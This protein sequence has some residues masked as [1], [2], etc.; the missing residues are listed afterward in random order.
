MSKNNE[1]RF[2]YVRNAAE[3]RQAVRLRK[4]GLFAAVC[5]VS[6]CVSAA[7]ANP[8]KP[9]NLRCERLSEPVAIDRDQPRLSWKL[10]S[11][12]RGEKQTAYR[13]LVASSADKLDKDVGDLWDTGKVESNQSIH[14]PYAGKALQSRTRC[15]WK[16][17]V[18]D[19]DGKPSGAEAGGQSGSCQMHT[20]CRAAGLRLK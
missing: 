15:F 12:T 17:R 18:W 10:E 13:V 14:V 16:V 4:A 3:P 1:I 5:A 8:A 9:Y 2:Q 20:E 6:M 7:A 11:A 19:K